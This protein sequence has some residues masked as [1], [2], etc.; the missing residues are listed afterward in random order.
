MENL[1]LIQYNINSLG[2]S[3]YNN[4]NSLVEQF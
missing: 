4:I 3:F 2:E 1:E